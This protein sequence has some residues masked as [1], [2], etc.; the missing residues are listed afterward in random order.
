M[1]GVEPAIVVP[2]VHWTKPGGSPIF[3]EYRLEYQ[4]ELRNRRRHLDRPWCQTDCGAPYWNLARLKGC[5]GRLSPVL[6]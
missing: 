5:S 1:G 4:K 6:M 3:L 2:D